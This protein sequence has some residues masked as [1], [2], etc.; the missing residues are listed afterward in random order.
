MVIK[1]LLLILFL[2]ISF[3]IPGF[4]EPIRVN[5]ILMHWSIIP[6]S[7][8]LDS[9]KANAMNASPSEIIASLKKVEN[10]LKLHEQLKASN[11][12]PLIFPVSAGVYSGSLRSDSLS[13]FDQLIFLYRNLC[14]R[15]AEAG[16]IHSYAIH[17]AL[18]GDMD[19]SLLMFNEALAIN[20][21]LKSNE[22]M[23]KNYQNLARIHAFNGNYSE[24][25]RTSHALVDIS[26][27]VRNNTSLANA[28]MSLAQSWTSQSNFQEAEAMVLKKALPL[29][30]YKLNDKLGAIKCYDQLAF[31]YQNQKRFSEAKWFFI[32]SNILARKIDHPVSIVNSLIN[33]AHVKMAIGDWQLALDDIKEAEKLAVKNHYQFQLIE[34]KKDLSELYSK[35]GDSNAANLALTQ[36]SDLKQKFLIPI[37]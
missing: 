26:I 1:R 27:R 35:M 11:N 33:L 3:F 17:N 23:I 19:K 16:A 7:S 14:D 5:P 2:N 24:V 18:N 29:L 28:Y 12:P 37:N 4:S 20:I 15:R 13:A 34:I 30:Y 31:I 8:S 25:I 10:T 22:G 32:Q 21:A 9:L 36:F 6:K